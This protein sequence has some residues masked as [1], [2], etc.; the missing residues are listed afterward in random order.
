MPDHPQNAP[1]TSAQQS[2]PQGQQAQPQGQQSP[3]PQPGQGGQDPRRQMAQMA[4]Q[5]AAQLK[6]AQQQQG[7]PPA[8]AAPA[9][10]A[11]RLQT[12]LG[13]FGTYWPLVLQFLEELG[14]HLQG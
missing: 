11:G 5:V 6:Q 3:P 7:P 9:A 12:I 2:Q 14:K 8:G 4:Q 13:G 10:D 1:V